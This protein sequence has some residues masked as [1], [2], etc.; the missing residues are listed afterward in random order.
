MTPDK[1]LG[2]ERKEAQNPASECLNTD[3]CPA[4]NR[5]NPV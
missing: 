2:Y 1:S 5:G 3:F 4:L